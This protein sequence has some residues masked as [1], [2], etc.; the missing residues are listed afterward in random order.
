M[1]SRMTENITALRTR[2]F[3]GETLEDI[4][5]IARREKITGRLIVDMQQGGASTVQIEERQKINN[6]TTGNK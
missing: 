1:A 5:A 6:L 4:I 3:S 2:V